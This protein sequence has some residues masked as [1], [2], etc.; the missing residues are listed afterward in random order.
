MLALPLVLE[1]HCDTWKSVPDPIP[2]INPKRQNFKAAVCCLPLAARYVH[3]L[4]RAQ[5]ISHNECNARMEYTCIYLGQVSKQG[6]QIIY[7][8]LTQYMF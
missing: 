5:T 7:V 1:V 4:T 2:S 8:H 6:A 3:T